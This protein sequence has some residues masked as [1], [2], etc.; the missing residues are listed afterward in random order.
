MQNT[1]VVLL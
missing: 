1:I